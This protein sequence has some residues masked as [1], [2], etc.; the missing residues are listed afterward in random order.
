MVP[1]VA[2]IGSAKFRQTIRP[3][4][5]VLY[6]VTLEEQLGS[7]FYMKGEARVNDRVAASVEF[8]CGVAP[9]A[10]RSFWG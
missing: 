6:R 5:H 9:R 7:A 8:Y 3:G 2:R 4:D 1:V 10:A